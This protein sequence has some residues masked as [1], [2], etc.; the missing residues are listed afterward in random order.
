MLS[1]PV[2][3]TILHYFSVIDLV[4]SCLQVSKLSPSSFVHVLSSILAS[5]SVSTVFV[6]MFGFT[7]AKSLLTSDILVI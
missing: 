7:Y 6:S 2:N 4:Q 1:L 3:K 5:Q